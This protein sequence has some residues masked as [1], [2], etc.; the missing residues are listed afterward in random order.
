LERTED[1]LEGM[2]VTLPTAQAMSLVGKRVK[3]AVAQ[4]DG[5]EDGAVEETVDESVADMLGSGCGFGGKVGRLAL[6]DVN[7]V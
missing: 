6:T 1:V 2:P 7:Y 5:E 4:E 3:S